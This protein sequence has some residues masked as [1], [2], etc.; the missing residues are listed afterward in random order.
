MRHATENDFEEVKSI[1]KPYTKTYFSHIRMDYI[2]RNINANRVILQDGVV[3][4]YGVYKRQQR[5]GTAIAKAGDA[6]IAQI[7]TAM[8]GKGSASI[9]LNQFFDFVK[10]N[11]WLTVRTENTRA[12]RF[13]EKN[14]MQKVGV[15]SWAKGSVAGSVYLY[16]LDA[17][18]PL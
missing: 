16:L 10:T 12:C 6:H 11:V 8:Q 17:I 14:G 4:I 9:V 13:Y 1:I 3:I 5:I 2:Q 7:A 15:T 18:L